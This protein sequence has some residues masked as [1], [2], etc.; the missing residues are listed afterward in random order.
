MALTPP[1]R[2]TPPADW[3]NEP[4]YRNHYRWRGEY[5]AIAHWIWNTLRPRSVLD[6]GC[7]NA[8]ILQALREMGPA[9]EVCGI[10][11]SA[12]AL[13]VAEPSI[14]PYLC[15]A[16]LVEPFDLRAH[17]FD[18]VICTEVA[19]HLPESAADTLIENIC[20][21]ARDTVLFTAA[22]PG[23]EDPRHINMQPSAY[24]ARRFAARGF[25]LAPD[26]VQLYQTELARK[27]RV[28]GWLW[29]NI[30]FFARE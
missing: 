7:G 29:T 5:V 17:P 6:L 25:G 23:Q 9:I 30:Q 11:S 16:D 24:W 28:A 26:L 2:F 1:A 22:P 14:R 12:A 20:R 15:I 19:E 13:R 3:Y 27:I 10:D 8:F 4:Y 18:L 21:H